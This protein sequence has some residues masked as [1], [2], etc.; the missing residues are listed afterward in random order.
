MGCSPWGRREPDTIGRL[1]PAQHQ[2]TVVCATIAAVKKQGRALL[3]SPGRNQPAT[4]KH[5]LNIFLYVELWEIK[6]FK[7]QNSAHRKSHEGD[8]LAPQWLGLKAYTQVITV[9]GTKVWHAV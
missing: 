8:C 1:S 9:L 3:L 5:S 4:E 6:T 7:I 2:Q